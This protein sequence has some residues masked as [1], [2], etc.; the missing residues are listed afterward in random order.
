MADYVYNY[1]A[2]YSDGTG[3]LLSD[4]PESGTLTDSQADTTFGDIGE[5]LTSDATAFAGGY[6]GTFDSGGDTFIVVNTGAGTYIYS[7]AADPGT[8]TPPANVTDFPTLENTASFTVCFGAGTRIA[9]PT[10]EKTVETLRVGDVVITADGREVPVLW[11]GLQKVHK[12]FTPAERFVPVRVKAGA[13]GDGLP[14][15]DLVL[16]ADHALIIDGIAINASAL[17][18]GT[19]VVYDPIESLPDI[20]TYYHVETEGHE[21]ILA[22]G[23]PAETYVDY[24]QRRVFSNYAEY[25]KLYGDARTISEMSIPR[26]SSARLLPPDIRNRLAGQFAA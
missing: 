17:V 24:V 13:L 4:G 15:T 1:V 18:N 5:T 6:Q 20:V 25:E 11:I 16:T 7:L 26:I 3:D 2:V 9:T 10:G 19:T 14:H 22:N 23:A 21:V 12:L 8:V